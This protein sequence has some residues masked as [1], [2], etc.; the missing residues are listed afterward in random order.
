M[1]GPPKRTPCP[2]KP[3]IMISFCIITSMSLREA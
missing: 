2:P 1:S 3:A